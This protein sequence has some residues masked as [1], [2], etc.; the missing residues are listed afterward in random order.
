MGYS[1]K[2]YV[3]PVPVGPGLFM[4]KGYP[5]S[6]FR[7]GSSTVILIFQKHRISFAEDIVG[8]MRFSGVESIFTR[9]FGQPLV[10]TEIMVRSAIGIVCQDSDV[11]ELS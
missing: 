7:P 2:E 6:L 9:G 5:K 8:N 11:T 4:R 3:N 10:E 1:E